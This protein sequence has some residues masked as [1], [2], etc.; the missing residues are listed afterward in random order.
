MSTSLPAPPGDEVLSPAAI[1][2][3]AQAAD[4]DAAIRLV[5][6]LLVER[7]YA[8][9][10]YLDAMRARE[11]MVSTYLGNGIALP[12]GTSEGQAAVLRT[13]LAV[14]QF[15]AGVAWGADEARLVIGLAA[16]SDEHIGI[17]SRL[18]G[19]LEDA[20][21]CARLAAT[22]DRHE[23]H[24]ALISQPTPPSRPPDP[25]PA[26]V[27]RRVRIAN[28]SG[29]HARPAAAIVERVGAMDASVT[30]LARERR[31]NALSITQ[32]IG[33]GAT[34]GDEVEVLAS[35]SEASAALEAVIEVLVDTG[36]RA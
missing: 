14:A 26:D 2:T 7:G 13:G 27:Q 35:G 21:L 20:D 18:A 23:I 3:G 4:R 19:I 16:R 22:P 1:V 5:G 15:P 34:P 36:D 32:L 31:A 11:A 17:L 33:L 6:G 24:R 25:P 12:H 30:I 8:T 28:P 10:A 29:L 9:A